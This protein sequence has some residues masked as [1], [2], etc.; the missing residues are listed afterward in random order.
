MTNWEDLSTNATDRLNDWFNK[1]P[2]LYEAYMVK[3]TFRDIYATAKDYI[4]ASKRFNDWLYA[5]PDWERFRAMKS[6]FANRKEHIINYWKYQWTNAYTESV[7]NSIKKIEKAG[8]G[9]KFDVLRDR[10]ILSIN[11]P[12]P[13]KFDHRRAVYVSKNKGRSVAQMLGY[14][15]KQALYDIASKLNVDHLRPI[16]LYTGKDEDMDNLIV[17]TS[18]QNRMIDYLQVLGRSMRSSD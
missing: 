4:E 1:F 17:L 8:R 7:N 6:T 16:T 15:K 14:K 11:N 5:V 13:D 12:A 3:E 2:E 9:Y 10:C 18:E